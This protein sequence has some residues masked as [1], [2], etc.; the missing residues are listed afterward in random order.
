MS[1]ACTVRTG[2]KTEPVCTAPEP[3]CECLPTQSV[4]EHSQKGWELENRGIMELT[5]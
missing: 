2:E 5:E 4:R 1:L 3:F